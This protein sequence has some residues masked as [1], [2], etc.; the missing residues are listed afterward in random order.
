MTHFCVEHQT[1][2]FRK[3]NMKSY[4]HPIKDEAGETTGWCNEP[5]EKAEAPEIKPAKPQGY[6]R[7]DSPEQR[8]SIESQVAAKIGC[9]LLTA[10][11]IDLNHILAQRVLLWCSVRLPSIKVETVPKPKQEPVEQ[12]TPQAQT[13]VQPAPSAP[14][15]SV[16]DLEWFKETWTALPVEAHKQ[17]YQWM[18]D[19][20]SVG[21]TAS[22]MAASLK[23]PKADELME[24]I[25]SL[26]VS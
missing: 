2:F 9:E 20:G 16:I 21:K 23:R 3:G 14:E 24:L 6:S 5:K 8:A 15:P 11:V 1:P 7:T 22:Q 18:K 4:A 13:A 26:E 17:I 25:T 12:S 10:K 19:N